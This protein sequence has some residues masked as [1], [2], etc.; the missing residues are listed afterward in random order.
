M[1]SGRV[2]LV[3][4]DLATSELRDKYRGIY[5]I[6]NGSFSGVRTWLIFSAIS[7][8]KKQAKTSPSTR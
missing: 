7:G 2:D 3:A 1:D 5:P 8:L 6:Y 4:V